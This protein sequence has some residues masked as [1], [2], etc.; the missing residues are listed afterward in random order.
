MPTV[1]MDR[2]I[3]MDVVQLHKMAFVYNAVNSGWKAELRDGKYVFSKKHEGKKEIYLD[4]YLENFIAA[5]ADVDK[6]L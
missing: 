2:S 1:S 6:L 5:N 4:S 3:H